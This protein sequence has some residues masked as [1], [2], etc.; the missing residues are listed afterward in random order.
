VDIKV[1]AAAVTITKGRNGI[2]ECGF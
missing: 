1:F 2:L